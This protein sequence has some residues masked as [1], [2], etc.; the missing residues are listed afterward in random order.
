MTASSVVERLVDGAVD[1]RLVVRLGRA[2]ERPR[3]RAPAASARSRPRG[4]APAPRSARP[5]A[6]RAR[7]TRRRRRRAAGS[8]SGATKHVTSITDSP[9]RERV[10]EARSCPRSGSSAAS[11]CRPSRGPTS[12]MRTAA[13]IVMR[14]PPSIVHERRRR[15]DLLA[16]RAYSLATTPRAAPRSTCSIFIASSTTSGWFSRT[17]RPATAILTM[18]PGIG[19][20][21]AAGPRRPA[22]VDASGAGWRRERSPPSEPVPS[23]PAPAV[24]GPHGAVRPDRPRS[25]SRR[26]ARGSTGGRVPSSPPRPRRRVPTSSAWTRSGR[27]ASAGWS[28]RA[29]RHGTAPA[30][31]HRG[32]L[33]PAPARAAIA[34]PQPRR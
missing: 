23:R 27:R 24:R 31:D 8:P 34:T 33:A 13:G 25:A 7:R 15:A 22:G 20:A 5:G 4:W 16:D 26:A 18:R 21:R 29:D 28:M 17:R 19:A 12:T 11:F 6:A 1:V 3:S 2:D 30:T 14:S 32:P 9:A 10:D